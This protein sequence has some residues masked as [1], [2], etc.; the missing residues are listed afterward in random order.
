MADSNYI[1]FEPAGYQSISATS[2]TAGSPS[3]LAATATSSQT[4]ASQFISFP[5]YCI[6]VPETAAIRWR[7][8]GNAAVNA[9]SGGMPLA[10]GQYVSYDGH[11]SQLSFISQAGTATVHVLLYRAS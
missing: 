7:D 8:D 5:N 9:A 4:R 11:P 10:V 6:F 1:A 3:V 2:S